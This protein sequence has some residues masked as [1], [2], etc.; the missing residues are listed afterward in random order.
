M[1][2]QCTLVTPDQALLDQPVYQVIL[3]AYDGLLGILTNRAPMLARLSKGKLRIDVTAGSSQTFQ[4]EGGVAQMLENKL[5]I[6]TTKAT[7]A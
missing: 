3:P 5:T 2:F 1:S 6:L 7:P 4:I